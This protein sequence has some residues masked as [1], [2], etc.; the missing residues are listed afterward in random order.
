MARKGDGAGHTGAWPC[1]CARHACEETALSLQARPQGPLVQE[2]G[3]GVQRGTDLRPTGRTSPAGA[4]CLPLPHQEG[5]GLEKQHRKPPASLLAQCPLEAVC[6]TQAACPP[7][8]PRHLPIPEQAHTRVSG[9]QCRAPRPPLLLSFT[10]S[11][12]TPRRRKSG[13]PTFT[14][15]ENDLSLDF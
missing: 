9:H 3:P 12:L 5:G 14:P 6:K 15:L 2:K 7:C 1:C 13:S 8:L 4:N 10:R 11:S